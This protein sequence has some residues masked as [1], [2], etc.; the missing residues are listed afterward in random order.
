MKNHEKYLQLSWREK[1]ENVGKIVHLF[2]NSETAFEKIMLLIDA[3]DAVH[4]F[5]NT[6]FFAPT[7]NI[8][9]D[10]LP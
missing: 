6:Y 9:E 8:I 5:E 2:Q 7:E 4:F 1:N 10:E 3:A